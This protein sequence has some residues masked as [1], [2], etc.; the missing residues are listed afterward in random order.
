MTDKT[1]ISICIPV[2]N[3][4]EN[5][6][7][8][9]PA[10]DRAL[11]GLADRYEWELVFTDNHSTDRT[12]A[13][14]AGIALD[15]PRVRAIRFSRNFG[16]QK[17]VLT[18]YLNA[19]GAC[20]IQLDADLQDPPELIPEMIAAWEKGARVVYGV[21]RTRQEGAVVT[22]LRRAFYRVISWL[23]EHPLPLDSG[24]FRL[25]DRCI[26]EALA[27]A[28]TSHPYLRG[29]IAGMGFAQVGIP[30]DRARRERGRSKFPLRAMLALA[31]DGIVSQSVVPLRIS[32]YV[33]LVIAALT[34]LGI[35]VY[36]A[37]RLFFPV[38]WPPGFTTLTVLLLLS[39]SLNALFLGIIGEYLARIY[40]QVSHRHKVIEEQR[41]G[42]ERPKR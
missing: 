32:T 19:R 38:D 39:I 27:A 2:Y 8:I 22:A 25:I 5:V 4:E 42:F 28:P 13:L 21:R 1:L 30:Y 10:V 6:D 7:R 31:V 9:I 15:D 36:A 34:F 16:Y 26:I 18:G 37:V 14:L 3:E 33:G 24:D 35:V 41:I 20:A 40:H 23:S 11:A 29:Q 12:F 17:S